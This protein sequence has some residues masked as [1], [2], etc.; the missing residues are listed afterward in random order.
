MPVTTDG[1]DVIVGFD[2]RRLQ[3]M[4]ARNRQRG[5]GLRVK[6]YPDGGAIVGSVR[7]D[8]PAARA[9]LQEGDIIQEL[10]GI[11]VVTAEDLERIASKWTGD[12][13]TSMSVLRDSE[14][15]TVILYG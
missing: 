9:G 13:P 5:L 1:S 3:A 11:P 15:S 6:D 10:S 7:P 8:S 12:R 14:R 4:A 2:A